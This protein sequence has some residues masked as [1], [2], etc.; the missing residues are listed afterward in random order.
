VKIRLLLS[1]PREIGATGQIVAAHGEVEVDDELGKSLLEQ[2]DVWGGVNAP[3][4]TKPAD[5][6]EKKS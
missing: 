5:N 4:G 2:S 3:K 6:E 1:R